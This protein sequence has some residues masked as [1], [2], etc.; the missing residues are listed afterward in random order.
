MPRNPQPPVAGRPSAHPGASRASPARSGA[1][2]AQLEL[3]LDFHRRGR[4]EDAER[5]YRQVLAQIP[6]QPDALNLLGTLYAERRKLTSA[7]QL[8]EL[9]LA[10]RPKD[11]AI[12]NNLGL[13]YVHAG[14]ADD[15][16]RLLRKALR[17]APDFIDATINLG[18][19]LRMVDRHREAID[20]YRRV[21]RTERRPTALI[22]LARALAEAG[23]S[24]EAAALLRRVIAENPGQAFPYI[25]LAR[26]LKFAEADPEP[27]QVA[28]LLA[29][30]SLSTRERIRL[31]YAAGKMM[32]DLGRYEQAFTYYSDAKRLE[33]VPFEADAHDQHVD[34]LIAAFTPALFDRLAGS[35]SES[36]KPLFIVGMPR[37]GTT[38][39]EQILA[40]HRS[41]YGAG[42]LQTINALALR[43]LQRIAGVSVLEAIA[44]LDAAT[45]GE[46]AAT[47]LRALDELAPSALRVTD[48]M[49][50]N[51]FHLGLIQLMFPNARV[52]HC[53]RDPVD[54]C[55]SCYMNEFDERHGYNRDLSDLGRYY[56]AYD[57]LMAHWR[58]VLRLP[59]H[60]MVYEDTV[61]DPERQARA[62]VAF[63]GLDWDDRCLAFHETDRAVLT[64]SQWQVRQPIYRQS[65]ER[66]RRYGGALGPLMEA[67][68]PLA[69]DP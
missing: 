13:T 12:L 29:G 34:R 26:N 53:R 8:I 65:V 30:S 14:R 58:A 35:G 50:H 9:A 25:E 6:D 37:S 51:F 31:F 16:V 61:A 18:R 46:L 5:V 33:T 1:L 59:I 68:G 17:I 62:L 42:E 39:T 49:P 52:V 60:E 57:R 45:V 55:V 44:A 4:I 20:C 43:S 2:R 10:R 63:A 56:R 27:A 22:G 64:P 28:A 11:P 40:S 36:D 69:P 7:I 66:W 54:T 47:Y 67:L 15:A 32:N 48:K 21:L 24:E 19:A 38:L 23:A 3:G 41:V